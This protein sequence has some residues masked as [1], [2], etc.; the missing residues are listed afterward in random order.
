MLLCALTRRFFLQVAQAGLVSGATLGP[1]APGTLDIHHISTGRGSSALVLFPNGTTMLIDA[2]A[3]QVTAR[4]R[5]Y[6]C[7]AKPNDSRRPGEWIG[8]YVLRQMRA[9]KRAEL[10]AVV[11]THFH[12]DHLAGL[13]DVAALVPVKRV[14]DR[15]YPDYSG[16]EPFE[17]SLIHI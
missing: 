16:L 5:A 8:R 15:A 1:W 13:A 17:L 12:D 3:H 7:D 14:I 2:G 11:I 9:A 10:D 6:V 4:S